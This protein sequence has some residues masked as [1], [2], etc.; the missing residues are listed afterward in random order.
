VSFSAPGV[1]AFLT[2]ENGRRTG[3]DPNRSLDSVGQQ[4]VNE[5]DYSLSEIVGSGAWQNNLDEGQVTTGWEIDVRDPSTTY[6]LNYSSDLTLGGGHISID[7]TDYV[8]RKLHSKST[9]LLAQKGAYKRMKLVVSKGK[10][11][12]LAPELGVGDLLSDT[13]IACKSGKISPQA[14]CDTLTELAESIETARANDRRTEEV[15]LLQIYGR[16]LDRLKLWDAKGS[17]RDWDDLEDE[18]SCRR[19]KYKKMTG[20]KIF[21]KE[22]AYSALKLDVNTLLDSALHKK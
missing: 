3:I 7:V 16:I 9:F 10:P 22:P 21:A 13:K 12:E 20:L 19:F 18:P 15:K 1:R 11:V 4:K 14:A 5:K 8:T 17:R 6:F 2:D